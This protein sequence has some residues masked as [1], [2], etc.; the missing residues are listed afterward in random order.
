[1]FLFCTSLTCHFS[2]GKRKMSEWVAHHRSNS[3]TLTIQSISL[4]KG[5]A[6]KKKKKGYTKISL[7][8][9][10]FR[11]CTQETCY[12]QMLNNNYGT[13]YNTIMYDV[14]LL[15]FVRCYMESNMWNL[16]II[17]WILKSRSDQSITLLI[18]RYKVKRECNRML[19]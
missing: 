17:I 19:S 12:G 6:K 10:W 7:W 14:K 3:L 18:S 5:V 16:I 8:I 4:S 1:M 13:Q 2:H 15:K 9:L 11:R